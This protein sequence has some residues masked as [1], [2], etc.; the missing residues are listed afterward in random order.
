MTH[1]TSWLKHV[2]LLFS[3]IFL[4]IKQS[5]SKNLSRD[6][7]QNDIHLL[8]MIRKSMIRYK[9]GQSA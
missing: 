2:F 5:I 4:A 6:W 9:I 3:S 8:H 7:S 1:L